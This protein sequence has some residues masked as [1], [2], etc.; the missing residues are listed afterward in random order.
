MRVGPLT[1][2]KR[3]REASAPTPRREPA[4]KRAR[5]QAEETCAAFPD[6]S[7]VEGQDAFFH[8]V[9]VEGIEQC[10]REDLR[11]VE[12]LYW[13]KAAEHARSEDPSTPGEAPV[14]EVPVRIDTARFANA[15][16]RPVAG[17]G[18]CALAAMH[19]GARH[20]GDHVVAKLP[21]TPTAMRQQMVAH[22]EREYAT[23]RDTPASSIPD[24]KQY[25]AVLPRDGLERRRM[26]DQ[27]G[28]PGSWH[29]DMGDLY[30]AIA[31]DTFD[32]Q[33]EVLTRYTDREHRLVFGSP[34]HSK[35]RWVLRLNGA[36]YE[37]VV[38]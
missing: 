22:V 1:G 27:L 17:D 19:A 36:H 6:L 32:L 20:L 2:K 3:E 34:D 31:A 16:T 23:W 37:P 30:V 13:Q 5:R 29:H 9:G 35:L 25:L 14:R 7:T 11:N 15:K 4:A 24:E 38:D 18:D 10:F 33:I 28:T 26:L 8:M 21:P 12:Q